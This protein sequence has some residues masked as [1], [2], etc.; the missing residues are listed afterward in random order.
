[1]PRPSATYKLRQAIVFIV[2]HAPGLGRV[3]LV[4]I[5]YLADL[6]FFAMFGRTITGST[7]IKDA[8]G[9]NLPILRD[10][11]KTMDS[12]EL[13]L[14]TTRSSEGHSLI[15]HFR[16]FLGTIELEDTQ[17][18]TNEERGLLSVLSTTRG[19]PWQ[20]VISMTKRTAPWR[21]AES[22]NTPRGAPLDFSVSSP[23][24]ILPD[25]EM[26]RRFVVRAEE[27]R[28]VAHR[29]SQEYG[30]AKLDELAKLTDARR[31]ANA[32]WMRP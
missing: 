11:C 23:K 19:K 17:L 4:K 18:T 1:M 31:A 24:Q 13:R 2:R 27:Y 7:Y 28:D 25:R 8:N 6:H 14:E 22:K 12:K 20:E 21:A 30:E 15:R 10:V 3:R 32:L 29:V 9:P 26:I 5:L 16:H